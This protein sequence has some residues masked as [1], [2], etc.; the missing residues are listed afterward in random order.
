VNELSDIPDVSTV[1]IDDP[2]L[3]EEAVQT[4]PIYWAATE[5]EVIGEKLVSRVEN[6]GNDRLVTELTNKVNRAY[7]YYFGVDPGGVHASSQILRGGDAG[8]LAEIR[9]N[10][11]RSLVNTL[12]N[13]ISSPKLVWTPKA[14][15]IDHDS[16]RECE[17]AAA[18]L[19]YYWQE[20]SVSSHA[21]RALE[22]ALVFTEGFVLESWDVDSGD[23]YAALGGQVA[24]TGDV[25][26]ENVSTWDVIRDPCKASWDELDWVIVRRFVNKYNLAAQYPEYATEIHETAASVSFTARRGQYTMV[27]DEDLVPC[28]YFFHKKCPALPTGRETIFLANK[29]VIHDAPLSYET[30]PLYRVS[31]GELFGT[32]YGYS[33]FMEILGIQELIDS[34]HTSIATN[35]STFATQNVAAEAGTEVPVDQLAGG[36][37]LLYYPQGGKPPSPLQLTST[38][39]EVFSHLEQLKKDQELLFGLNSVVRGEPQSG[40]LSGSALALLQS[41]AIQQ[42]ST[43]QASYLRFVEALGA[44]TL[45]VIRERLSAEKQIAIV[46]K[47]S[48][49]LVTDSSYTGSDLD[50]VRKVRVEI[51]NPM[52]QTSAGRS[53]MAKELIGMNLIK[54]V[55][56]YQQVLATGRLEPL[57]EGLNNELMLI[58]A[59][60]ESL[61]AGQPVQ[62]IIIDDHMLHCR[63]HRSIL[64]NPLARANPDIVNAVLAHITEHEQLYYT[65]PPSTLMMMGQQPPPMMG[66]GMPPP[67]GAEGAAPMPPGN[68]AADSPNPDMPSLPTN[69]ATG[70]EWNPTDGGG[71]VPS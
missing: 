55:E 39:A 63:E 8:E 15:N 26:I 28:Y 41:Q 43:I 7:Q 27:E 17:L 42:S 58:R 25:R 23:D 6:Y 36:M 57:T 44:G 1:E 69:P 21:V 4:G 71:V 32:P 67:P 45:S 16:I 24:K 38:P 62:A 33:P 10:H 54:S 64:A 19:E 11:A 49:F 31:A 37:R 68:P 9:V 18:I 53:E 14:V 22:E 70:A 3:A 47:S 56:Q 61:S 40:E 50:R 66:G 12:L 59:E 20:R 60:N 2:E 48:Q 34:L 52:S 13:L 35:Q 5:S 51:G 65:A 46:G 30:I 29:A